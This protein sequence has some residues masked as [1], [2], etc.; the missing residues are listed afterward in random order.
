[1]LSLLFLSFESN[2]P[3]PQN[4]RVLG[5]G[6]AWIDPTLYATAVQQIIGETLDAYQ[7]N[8]AGLSWQRIELAMAML[9]G[10]GTCSLASFLVISF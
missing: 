1:L 4:L 6:I 8:P 9:Y 7:A 3:F 5:D 2:E 10:F